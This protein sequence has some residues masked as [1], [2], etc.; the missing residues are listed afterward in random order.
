LKVSNPLESIR[1][2]MERVTDIEV[3]AKR[4]D[5]F[6]LPL[7]LW[8]EES[9]ILLPRL[10]KALEIALSILIADAASDQMYIRADGKRALREIAE[11]LEATE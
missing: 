5:E 2:A 10:A 3:R 1:A 4:L 6:G 8:T 11:A 7:P 9:R